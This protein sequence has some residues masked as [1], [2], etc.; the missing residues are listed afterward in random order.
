[1]ELAASSL[2]FGCL[3]GAAL[4]GKVGDRFGRQTAL[5]G[6]ALLF[7]LSAIGSSV[8]NGFPSSSAARFMGGLAIGLASA[9]TPVYISE[10]APPANRDD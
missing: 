7:T 10:V 5:K 6:T 4:A 2:L 8:S 3:I 9:L 1:M